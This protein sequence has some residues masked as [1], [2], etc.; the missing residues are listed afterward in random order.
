M[1]V[2]LFVRLSELAYERGKSP[3][4]SVEIS[5]FDMIDSDKSVEQR[6]RILL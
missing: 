1:S 2:L 3:L 5:P 4:L 6:R